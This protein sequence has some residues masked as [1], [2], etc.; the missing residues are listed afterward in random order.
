[1]KIITAHIALC[2]ASTLAAIAAPAAESAGPTAIAPITQ[3]IAP[4]DHA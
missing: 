2:A 1:M 4:K 3:I